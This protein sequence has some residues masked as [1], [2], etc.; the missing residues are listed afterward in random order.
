MSDEN[1]RSLIVMA[2]GFAFGMTI[3]VILAL[4]GY[5]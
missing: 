1:L 2:R 3:N 4:L 5:L